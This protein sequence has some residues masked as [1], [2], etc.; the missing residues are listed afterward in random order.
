MLRKV[1]VFAILIALVLAA[2]PNVGVSAKGVVNT[3][4]ERKWDQLV[5][6]FNN[7]NFNHGRMHKLV[8]NWLKTDKTAKAAERAEVQKHLAV[9]SAAIEAAAVIVANH[10]GF[11]SAGKII[12]RDL[13]R[14]SIKDLAYYLQQHAG[15]VRNLKE[16]TN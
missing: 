4:L 9:C 8:D 15:S 13:A 5:T 6:N 1:T 14:K 16:H 10:A 3:Q 11:D 2:F 12:D 7:Q